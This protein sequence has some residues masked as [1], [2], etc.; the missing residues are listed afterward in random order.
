M[1][2]FPDDYFESMT[3]HIF[4]EYESEDYSEEE[5]ADFI[6]EGERKYAEQYAKEHIREFEHDLEANGYS[7]AEFEGWTESEQKEY[8]IDFF[9]NAEDEEEYIKYMEGIL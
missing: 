1:G 8:C 9:G 3:N 7:L 6:K 4:D 2:Y 5:Y